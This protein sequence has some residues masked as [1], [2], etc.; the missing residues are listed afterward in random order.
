MTL[1]EMRVSIDTKGI[2]LHRCQPEARAFIDLVPDEGFGSEQE[3]PL[4]R[5][6]HAQWVGAFVLGEAQPEHFLY[7]LGLVARAGAE[8]WL[9]VRHRGI[10][11]DLLMDGDTLAAAKCWL[12]GSCPL[13]AQRRGRA[14]AEAAVVGAVTAVPVGVSVDPKIARRTSHSVVVLDRYRERR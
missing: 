1:I 7:R 14:S 6:G 11:R 12:V 5:L 8:F 10:E 2:D 9:T 4:R 13:P 3:L